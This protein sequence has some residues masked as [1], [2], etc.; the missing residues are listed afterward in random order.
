MRNPWGPNGALPG[1][2]H[3]LPP[4]GP[5]PLAA[6]PTRRPRRYLPQHGSPRAEQAMRS[7]AAPRPRP[8]PGACAARHAASQDASPPHYPA[9]D[10]PP[11]P[12]NARW[13]P[14][15][16]RAQTILNSAHVLADAPPP[17]QQHQPTPGVRARGVWI[18]EGQRRASKAPRWRPSAARDVASAPTPRRASQR[19]ERR[20]P[21]PP[22]PSAA[23]AS[24]GPPAPPKP[25]ARRRGHGESRESA[26]AARTSG[27]AVPARLSRPRVAASA[28][29]AESNA[30]ALGRLPGG[31]RGRP[32]ADAPRAR[33]ARP[34]GRPRVPRPRPPVQRATR[35]GKTLHARRRAD[36]TPLSRM[37]ACGGY[38]GGSLG[39]GQRRPRCG[40][41]TPP[42]PP[43]PRPHRAGRGDVGTPRHPLSARAIAQ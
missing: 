28:R 36:A 43:S 11:L 37:T 21:E 9:P 6:A 5:Q 4:P 2:A 20:K 25:G 33:P 30:C 27:A 39:R 38:P 13:P 24:R 22:A 40:R 17:P 35:I 3:E 1:P 23:A 32:D 34:P 29:A 15:T 12:P 10:A 26:R 31:W 8:P 16:R 19:C 41:A 14:W 18:A 7:A 42:T